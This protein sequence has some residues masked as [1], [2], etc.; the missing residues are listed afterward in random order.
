[1]CPQPPVSFLVCKMKGL[2][3]MPPAL[4][5]FRSSDSHPTTYP[6]DGRNTGGRGSSTLPRGGVTCLEEH[7]IRRQTWAGLPHMSFQAV[8]CAK[9]PVEGME[10][11]AGT[12]PG[13]AC[14]AVHRASSARRM[15]LLLT[16][17]NVPREPMAAL[18]SSSH[19]SFDSPMT[20][21]N[22]ETPNFS[23]IVIGMEIVTA[24]WQK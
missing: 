6:L 15:H 9:G 17:T 13:S 21:G 23:T 10:G 2:D 20:S 16:C 11:A 12:P 14:W 4:L 22:L 18:S 19:P 3:L 24:S 8:R 7:R 1:M 5:L